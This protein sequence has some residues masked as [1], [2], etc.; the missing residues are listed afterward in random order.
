[1]ALGQWGVTMI[2]RDDSS[3]PHPQRIRLTPHAPPWPL[4]P[5]GS[6]S[7]RYDRG[8]T[9]TIQS[10]SHRHPNKLNTEVYFMETR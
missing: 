6:V 9:K 3:P 10:A 2:L 1:V 7:Y 5:L 4:P 8:S